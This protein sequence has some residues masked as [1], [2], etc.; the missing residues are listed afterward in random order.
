MYNGPAAG[1]KSLGPHL[2]CGRSSSSW[3]APRE[4]ITRLFCSLFASTRRW[5]AEGPAGVVASVTGRGVA[6]PP[7]VGI[8]QA[9]VGWGNSKKWPF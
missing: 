6:R 8:S 9:T 3:G 7:L 4:S 1:S 5:Y 2:F